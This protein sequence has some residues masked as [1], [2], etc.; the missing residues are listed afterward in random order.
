V[1]QGI[2]LYDPNYMMSSSFEIEG[3]HVVQLGVAF[4]QQRDQQD[5]LRPFRDRFYTQPNRIYMDGNSLGLASKDAEAAVLRALA[6]WKTNGIDGWTEGDRPWY[7]MAEELGAGQAALLGARPEEVV[8][9]G[10]TTSNL[11]ALVATFYQPAGTRTKILADELNF[12]SDIYALQSQIRLRGYDPAVHLVL[13]PSE[14]GRTL[15]EDRIIGAMT[16]EIALVLLPGVLY[17]S[18]QLLDMARLTSAAHA[19]GILIGLDLCHSAGSVPHQLHDWGV[20]FAFW[21]TYKY[22]N[23]GPGAVASLF[24]H[25]RHFG[26]LPGLTGWFGMDKSKQFDMGLRF[27]PAPGAGA[28]QMGTPSVLGMAALYGSLQIFA[29]AGMDAIRAKSLAQTAYLIDL[30]DAVLAPYGF[31]VGSPRA[32]AQRGGHVALEHPEAIQICKA[33]KA[34]GVIPDFRFPNVVRLA[35]IALYSTYEEIWQTVQI[36]KA[37][38]EGGEHLLQSSERG[39]VA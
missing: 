27:E 18:G 6:D 34:R 15:S 4:A 31:A 30:I 16:D 39:T 7:Y 2:T 17:R 38:V 11:H 23:A 3:G 12:P 1:K 8:V 22:L 28:W 13:V 14:D 35:P 29:E 26:T 25:E 37:I 9:T 24:V 20:D 10:S 33:L 21:C 32:E 19:R 5:P 36:L